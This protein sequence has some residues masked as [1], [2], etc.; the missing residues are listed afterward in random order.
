VLHMKK[1][2]LGFVSQNLYLKNPAR[3]QELLLFKFEIKGKISSV[4]VEYPLPLSDQFTFNFQWLSRIKNAVCAQF[5]L[6]LHN[7]FQNHF[8]IRGAYKNSAC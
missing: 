5:T 1:Q 4:C 6:T 7:P 2:R 8:S 3:S